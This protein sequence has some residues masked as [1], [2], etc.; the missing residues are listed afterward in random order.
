MGGEGCREL[1]IPEMEGW[2]HSVT[3]FMPSSV[4]ST[5]I[6][7]Y[8]GYC[9]D[10]RVLALKKKKKEEHPPSPPI[11]L[12]KT[13]VQILKAGPQQGSPTN[14]MDLQ[15]GQQGSGQALELAFEE[16]H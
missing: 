14:P 12:W 11:C 5:D 10:T 6:K 4:H 16:Q 7:D 2:E 9:T 3:Q 8:P 13:L 1:K 15:R